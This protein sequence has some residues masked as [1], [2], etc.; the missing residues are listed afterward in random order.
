MYGI[1]LNRTLTQ[2]PN[3][4]SIIRNGSVV[5]SN[6]RVSFKGFSGRVITDE[7]GL[8]LPILNVFALDNNGNQQVY[9][10]LEQK[11]NTTNTTV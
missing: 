1:A 6:S 11:D 4:P 8:R 2:Y 3:D 5:I 7:N 9:L 10:I